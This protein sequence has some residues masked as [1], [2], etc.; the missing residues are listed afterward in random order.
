MARAALVWLAIGFTIGALML[1][2]RTMPGNWRLWFGPTHG[3]I[4]FV[5]W[6]LQFAVGVAY[7]LLPRNRTE[8]QPLGYNDR[9]AFI[10]LL[11]LNGGLGLRVIV[12]PT[13]RMGHELTGGDAILVV[14][15]MAHLAAIGIIVSQLWRRIIPRRVIRN[16]PGSRGSGARAKRPG[17][18]ENTGEGMDAG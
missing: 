3:H 10:A 15:A 9:L 14:S 4:L 8:D 17:N 6:F 16:R 18:D 11:A 1:A 12:E 5:G 7:W 13:S 2:D